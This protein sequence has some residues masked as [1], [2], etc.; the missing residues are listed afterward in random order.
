M[1]SIKTI[2]E[3][4]IGI[5]AILYFFSSSVLIVQII[6]LPS[7]IKDRARVEN[8]QRYISESIIAILF[9]LSGIATFFI[10]VHLTK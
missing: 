2:G 5:G 7:I 6:T 3:I 4:I 9:L 10:G 8:T 1:L